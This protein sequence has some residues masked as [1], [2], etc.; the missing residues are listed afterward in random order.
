M[1]G[2][3][4]SSL[5]RL[6]V[7]CLRVV[8]GSVRARWVLLIG[9]SILGSSVLIAGSPSTLDQLRAAAETG[10]SEAEYN[11]G[12]AYRDG[13][14]GFPDLAKSIEWL[15][16][17]ANACYAPAQVALGAAFERGSGVPKSL[18]TA[19]RWYRLAAAQESVEGSYRLALALYENRAFEDDSA[20][21]SNY[22]NGCKTLTLANDQGKSEQLYS[23]DPE[24]RAEKAYGFMHFAAKSGDPD[25]AYHV[26]D[27]LEHGNGV[28][29]NH[30]EAITW[31]RK[32]AAQGQADAKTSLA[33]LHADK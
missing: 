25:A 32:A 1:F 23:S 21:D 11:L 13:S 15:Q 12:V 3:N 20:T 14:G 24:V 6:L 29:M 8:T 22:A 16:R 17:A 28:K 4:G 19:A 26:G 18:R 31:Y 27:A 2:E 9:F 5:A 30:E 10:N 7:I 33:R